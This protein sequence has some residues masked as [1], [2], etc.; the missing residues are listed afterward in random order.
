MT[1]DIDIRRAEAVAQRRNAWI[2]WILFF[3]VVAAL[4]SPIWWA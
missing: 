3:I 1:D 2:A 4:T